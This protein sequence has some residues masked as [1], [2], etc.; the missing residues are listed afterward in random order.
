MGEFTLL[1]SY[2]LLPRISGK[3][4][5]VAVSESERMLLGDWAEV[6][7]ALRIFIDD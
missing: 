5:E 7:F 3:A 2:L 1:S 4:E 6:L